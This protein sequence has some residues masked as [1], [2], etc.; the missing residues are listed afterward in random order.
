MLSFYGHVE[1]LEWSVADA[2][3]VIEWK[4]L[5]LRL[6]T[7]QFPFCAAMP[8]EAGRITLEISNA[9][10]SFAESLHHQLCMARFRILAL[11]G[12]SCGALLRLQHGAARLV[13]MSC[14]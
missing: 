6:L 4:V 2:S 10:L 13:Q 7:F 11:H 1:E 12:E 3:E 9:M 14:R 5:S 8:L